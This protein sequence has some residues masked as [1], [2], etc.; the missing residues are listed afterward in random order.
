MHCDKCHNC[1]ETE[2]FDGHACDTEDDEGQ[3]NKI[4]CGPLLTQV[5]GGV[6]LCTAVYCCV[7]L[8]TDPFPDP[9]PGPVNCCVL[10]CA[11]CTFL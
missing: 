11:L 2:D 3:D 1:I 5:S 9:F 10:L 7:L 4:Y 6:L 8:C